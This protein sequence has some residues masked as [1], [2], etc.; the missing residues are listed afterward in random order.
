MSRGRLHRLLSNPVYIGKAR[1]H[2]D[3]YEGEHEGII[4]PAVFEAAQSLLADKSRNRKYR[5]YSPD[6]HL[7]TGLVVDETGDRLGPTHAYNH[8][9]RYRYYVS[10]RL[11]HDP[12]SKEGSWRIAAGELEGIVRRQACELLQD[13][14]LIADWL[15]ERAVPADRMEG[16]L[17]AASAMAATLEG[18]AVSEP[19]KKI[20]HELFRKITLSPQKISFE[21]RKQALVRQLLASM[22][23]E[24]VDCWDQLSQDPTPEDAAEPCVIDRPVAIKRRGLEA[25]IVINGI[26]REPEASLIDLL[27]R[28]HL[29]LVR[30]TDGSVSSIV[31]LARE[32]GVYRADISRVLPLAFLSPAITEAILTGRQPADLTARALA[33]SVDVPYLWSEQANALGM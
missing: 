2:G 12:S 30:L 29:Y 6:I 8:G 25:R 7:L 26:A 17:S 10:R 31:E 14:T 23:R 4:E 11:R 16:A 15:Q 19:R 5:S 1:Y 9:K 3:V 22:G 28:A 20:L 32:L 18:D 24:P 33:R 27:A 21:V 13:R